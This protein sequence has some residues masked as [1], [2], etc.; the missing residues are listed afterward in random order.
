MAI[1][2]IDGQYVEIYGNRNDPYFLAAQDHA[3]GFG[4]LKEIVRSLPAGSTIFDVGANIG[5][6]ALTMAVVAP[7]C[8]IICFEPSPTNFPYLKKNVDCFGSNRIT[9]H[10]IAAS[11]KKQRLHLFDGSGSANWSGG[12]SHIVGENHSDKN[13]PVREIDAI[14]LDDF[15]GVPPAFMKIDVEGH[16]PEVMAGAKRIIETTRPLIYIEFNTWTLNAYGGHSPA[17]FASALFESFDV[18]GFNNAGALLH[19]TLCERG[20]TDLVLRLK[21]DKLAPTLAQMSYPPSALADLAAA[22]L[23]AVGAL[24]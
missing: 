13:W 5:L 18:G 23:V 10:Q 12:W 14:R 8:N 3:N 11:N 9:I 20:L 6:S 21:V 7:Q 24:I 16:E 22:R 2:D 19:A 1:V 17:A 15:E 4:N